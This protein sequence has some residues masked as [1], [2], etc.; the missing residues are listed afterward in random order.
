MSTMTLLAVVAPL[1]GAAVSRLV[2]Q[3]LRTVARALTG[4]I[5]VALTCLAAAHLDRLSAVFAILISVVSFA[6]T[7]FSGSL[8]PEAPHDDAPWQRRS[9]Y[10]VLLGAFWSSMLYA[11]CAGTFTGV[12]MG[13]SGTTLATTFLVGYSG[14]KPALEAAWKYLLLCSVGVA[15]ALIGMLLLGRAGMA[16]GIPP[17]DALSW[18]ALA[19]R[20]FAP[21]GELVRVSLLLMLVGFAT[22]AGLAPMHA[23]LPDAH[24]KAPAP[25]SALL[26]GVLVSSALYALMRVRSVAT[27]GDALLFDRTLIVI[28]AA[29]VL[30]ASTLMLAQRDVKRLLS[31][32]TIEHSGLIALAL[33]IGTPLA[34]FAA[35]F[36][37]LSH[38][39]TKSTAFFAIGIVHYKRGSTA[40]ASLRGL[41][42]DRGGKLLLAALVGLAGFPPF[43]M[44]LSEL[45]IVIAAAAAHQWVALA[46]ALLGMTL[47]FAALA[48]LAIDTESGTSAS[49]H[50]PPVPK[51]ALAATGIMAAVAVAISVL[52][53]LS[54]NILQ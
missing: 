27:L 9:I 47:G 3:S 7:I 13:I 33:G 25:I 5:A 53:F 31:Y 37:T 44:F 4:A 45:L 34:V 6:A 46:C 2:N 20:G 49:R 14:G 26:S 12:W 1:A 28:G 16:A 23:W 32:S 42:N 35:L 39:C 22:K 15:L 10:F 24:S 11:V 41:W 30:V 8:F 48:R 52:P 36:H 38:A 29:S 43:G 18:D 19:R 50:T 40:I 21:H 51:I 17:A 54:V